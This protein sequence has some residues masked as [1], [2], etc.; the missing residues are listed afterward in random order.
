MTTLKNHQLINSSASREWYT[1]TR[2]MDAVRDVMGHIDL[3]PASCE[4]ANLIVKAKHFYTEAENGFTKGWF[5]RVFLNPPY[6]YC[7]PDGRYKPNGGLTAQGHWSARLAA[8]YQTGAV[9]EAI[10]LINA[11]TGE[12]WFQP[13]WEYPVVFVCPRIKFIRGRNTDPKKGPTK[14]NAFVYFGPRVERFVE[15]FQQFGRVVLPEPKAPGGSPRTRHDT[16]PPDRTQA[17]VG[18]R[19]A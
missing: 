1:P 6:G 10:L 8:E 12:R 4:E 18:V 15:V 14:G 19:P 11:N 5:G 9:S 13:L 3:D 7:Y 2:Y 16:V 17:T